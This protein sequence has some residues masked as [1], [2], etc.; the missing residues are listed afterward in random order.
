MKS[1]RALAAI[2]AALV[3]AFVVAPGPLAAIPAT[4]D[5]ADE[6]RLNAA[7]RKGFVEY[8][9]SGGDRFPADLQRVVDY[10]LRYHVVKAAISAILLIVLIA[11]IV[12]LCRAFL[13][14][15]GA[16]RRVALAAAGGAVTMLAVLSLV[17]AMANAHGA[18]APFASL[19]PMLMDG[20]ADGAL[21]GTLAQIR[22]QLAGG[23]TEPALTAMIDDFA[24]YHLALAVIATIVAVALAGLS[25][26]LWRRFAGAAKAGGARAVFG[27]YGVLSAVLALAVTVVALAN[28]STA[29]DPAPALL[30]FY[31]GGW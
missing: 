21:A 15:G 25:V 6:R 3:V 22:D 30:A 28:A 24:V 11:L 4:G 7:F 29:A 8:W 16:G 18:V 13:G 26:V 1:T 27:S 19:G 10:W 5:L 20:P 9:N 23:G 12:R 31:D 17:T 2:A 14:A